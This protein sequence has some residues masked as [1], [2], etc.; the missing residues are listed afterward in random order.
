MKI[1]EQIFS[2]FYSEGKAEA[3][4]LGGLPASH[5]SQRNAAHNISI[6]SA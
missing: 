5:V 4:L 6:Q 2:V 3:A 1:R